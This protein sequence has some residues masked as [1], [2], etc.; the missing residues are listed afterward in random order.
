[1]LATR[2]EQ[3]RF[4]ITVTADRYIF[5]VMVSLSLF[6]FVYL[7]QFSN[8]EFEFLV[9]PIIYFLKIRSAHT[10]M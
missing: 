6:H 9:I 1:M 5:V 7:T 2:D 3:H 8:L 4:C 10:Q